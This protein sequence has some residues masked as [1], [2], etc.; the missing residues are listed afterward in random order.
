M[1]PFGSVGLVLKDEI[2]LL[3]IDVFGLILQI[4]ILLLNDILFSFILASHF[5]KL[6]IPVDL[7]GLNLLLE[8]VSLFL[9]PL[10]FLFEATLFGHHTLRTE[11][12][13]LVKSLVLFFEPSDSAIELIHL[14]GVGLCHVLKLLLMLGVHLLHNRVMRLV[15][16][17][18]AIVLSFMKLVHSL[19]ELLEGLLIILLSLL[20]LLLKEL[21]FTFPKGFLFFEFTLEISMSS[22]HFVVLALPL[23]DL[24]S[25]TQ[26]TLR[27]SLIE[28]LVRF[29][30]PLV[31]NFIVFDELLLLSLKILVFFNLDGLLSFELRLRLL[32]VLLD[33]FE[34]L[35]LLLIFGLN[36]ILFLLD[37]GHALL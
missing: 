29:L 2:S 32:D 26:L 1:V 3:S 30:K 27:Q 28:L 4:T 15:V 7:N 5:V 17:V 34:G 9:D 18:L 8:P 22:L 33:L 24:F 16:F 11:F 36:T 25:N 21:K 23:L 35:S 31:L 6:S 13:P 37:S 19:S 12:Q 14:G 10:D 20:L